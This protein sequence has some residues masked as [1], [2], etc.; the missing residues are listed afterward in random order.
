MSEQPFTHYQIFN[1]T[2]ETLEQRIG[3][4]YEQ[5]QDGTTT[6]QLLLA[7]RVRYQL[8]AEEFAL[9]LQDLVRYLF[10]RTKATKVMKRFFYYFADYFEAPEWQKL[11]LKVFPVRNFI[12]K[13]KSI[14][15]SLIAKFRPTET[16]VP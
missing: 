12:E 14:A 1:L 6:I 11:C 15:G 8:G 7:L 10:L 3:E 16:A 4:Y 5:T 13:A 2:L 9:V